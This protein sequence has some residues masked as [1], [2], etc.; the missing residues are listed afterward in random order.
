MRPQIT[1]ALKVIGVVL[2][3]L[4]VLTLLY[5]SVGALRTRIFTWYSDTQLVA[6][7]GIV[8]NL[9]VV[10]VAL[11]L[12]IL[13]EKFRQPRFHVKYGQGPPWQIE[14]TVNEPEKVQLLHVRLQ[15]ENVGRSYEESCEVRVEQV[16]RLFSIKN[17]DP[18]LIKY[19][20]PRSLKWVGRD[21][22]PIPLNVGAFDFVDL[23][24]RH[25]ASLESF[26]LDFAERGHLD[27]GLDEKNLVGY[28]IV[29]TVYGKQAHPKSFVFDLSWKTF[30]LSPI[31][32]K[33]L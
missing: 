31:L 18:E 20:D 6:W 15:I 8:V 27:L 22:K 32:I 17:K 3:G 14:K 7:V 5:P 24:A 1:K 16:F 23:G 29:G 10:V 33:E 4:L 12:N 28:R 30:E 13:L 21:T 9:A 11:F 2:V 25:P 19:H 26:R